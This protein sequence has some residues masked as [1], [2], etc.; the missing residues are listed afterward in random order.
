MLNPLDGGYAF[1]P[2]AGGLGAGVAVRQNDGSTVR[3]ASGSLTLGVSGVRRN[4]AVA[5]CVDGRL[6]AFCEQERVT[7]M[8]GARLEA[9]T[10][11]AEA[12]AAVL[13]LAGNGRSPA[14]DQ[15]ATAEDA[16]R[17]PAGLPTV[18]VDHHHAHAAA[19][20]G[21]SPFRHAA[22]LVCDHHSGTPISVWEAGPAGLVPVSWDSGSAVG[23]ATLYSE[24]AEVFGF[25]AG[26][27]HQFEAL[28]R[29][30]PGD[31]VEG[32]ERLFRY[33]DGRVLVSTG[34][35]QAVA[36]RLR[37]GGAPLLVHSARVASAFQRQIG[38]LLTHLAQ[39]IRAATSQPYL[40]LGGGLFYN[41]YFTTLVRQ[42]GL[43]DDV[44]VAPNP[45]N[46]GLAAGAAL[47][48]SGQWPSERDAVSAFL[49]PAYDLEEIKATLDNCKLSYECLSE[50]DVIGATVDALKRGHLVGWFQGRME[51][52][53]RALGNRSILASPLSSYVLDNLNVFLKQRPRHRAYGL[54]VTED[55][56][57]RFFGGPPTSRFMEYEYDVLDCDRLRQVV[58]DGARTLR[59]QTIPEADGGWRR[60]RLLHE[61]F[62]D[63]TGVPVLVNTSFNGFSEPIVCS[64]RD[65]V[66]VFFG[67]GL[68]M[69]VLDRFILRK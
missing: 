44:F 38:R 14:V 51:W 37:E 69:L 67:T 42:S 50:G 49:G 30:H 31:D 53:H 2:G 64:P 3:L 36:A 41:T 23:L 19:A 54:S 61:A 35:K 12:L 46:T 21:T 1:R 17:L 58:P 11:P 8:R 68:D 56:S 63:A 57:S 6:T 13:E 47:A 43:F 25:A 33:A 16:V 52:A 20:F 60:F 10:L 29:L 34:W 45:G 27:E 32:F 55:T 22:V 7:R 24:G 5:A 39:D 9:G 28:A 65:A 15:Y 40:C 18:R 48:A 62:G 26:Q 59:V 66:R 4:A